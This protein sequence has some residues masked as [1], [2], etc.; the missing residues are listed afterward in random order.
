[1]L[2]NEEIMYH[3]RFIIFKLGNF[4][5]Q[6]YNIRYDLKKDSIL[7]IQRTKNTIEEDTIQ[8]DKDTIQTDHK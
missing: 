5:K 6:I 3:S 8:K 4:I 7:I 1:M 2:S